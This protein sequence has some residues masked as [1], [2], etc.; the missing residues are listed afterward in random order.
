M[1]RSALARYASID[2]MVK[3]E[4]CRMI[5]AYSLSDARTVFLRVEILSVSMI[6][7][8]STS[9]LSMIG[10]IAR[11]PPQTKFTI[12]AFYLFFQMTGDTPEPGIHL[13]FISAKTVV[14]HMYGLGW[15]MGWKVGPNLT[16]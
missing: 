13:Q 2:R 6:F 3:R 10:P 12:S 15:A 9:C 7:L 8:I 5:D 4:I 11:T 14:M 16:L 1:A